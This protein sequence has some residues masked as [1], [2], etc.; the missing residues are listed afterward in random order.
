MTIGDT[1]FLSMIPKGGSGIYGQVTGFATKYGI[2][3]VTIQANNGKS[4]YAPVEHAQEA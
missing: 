4:Y 2:T 1:I 3:Y